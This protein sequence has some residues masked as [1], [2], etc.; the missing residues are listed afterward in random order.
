MKFVSKNLTIFFLTAF[1][2][3]IALFFPNLS[4]ASLGGSPGYF[5]FQ[6]FNN[7]FYDQQSATGV[8]RMDNGF[9]VAKAASGIGNTHGSSVYMDTCISVSGAIDLRQ[10]NTIFLRSDLTLDNGVTF[11]SGGNIYGYDRALILNGDLTIPAGIVIHIGDRIVIDGRGHKLNLGNSAQLFVDA[12][13]TLTLKNLVLD[14]T[15]NQPGHPMVQCAT[16]AS[17]LC[18]DN[19]EIIPGG[20][21]WFNQGQLFIHN[22]VAVTG[23]SALVYR[24]TKPLMI[25]S[26]GRLF[27]D[28]NTTFSV[29]PA[30]FT[31]CPYST[32][33][34]TTTNNFIWMADQ[35]SQLYLNGCT[36][37]TTATGCRFRTGTLLFDNKVNLKSNSGMSIS[38]S[39]PLTDLSNG[40]VTT[41]TTPQQVAWSPDSRY[42]ATEN[43]G[44][45]AG[46]QIF[47]FN[48]N[49]SPQ[50]VSL[51]WTITTDYGN[52]S[53]SPDDRFLAI[54]GNNTLRLSIY[55]LNGASSAPTLL[56]S[57]PILAGGLPVWSPDGRFIALPSTSNVLNVYRFN[58]ISPV[59]VAT[60]TGSGAQ[61]LSWSPDGQFIAEVSVGGVIQIFKFNGINTLTSVGST[62][63]GFGS[64]YGMSWSPDGRFLAIPNNAAN[65][66]AVYFFNGRE[67]PT[68]VGST[69]AAAANAQI[70]SWSPDG[71]FI[72]TSNSAS[73]VLQ[74]FSFN[75]SSAPTQVGG[76]I[77]IAHAA[78]G[79]AWSPD[80][81]FIAAFERAANKLQVFRINYVATNPSPQNL[82]NST[83]FG[84][85]ALGSSYDLSARL[86]S[87]SQGVIDGIVND[88][89]VN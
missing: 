43:N 87:E 82:S 22:D 63:T 10:T 84:N 40:G 20:D 5:A 32:F 83:V 59:Q 58:G 1:V 38:T 64:V 19:S 33:P 52:F 27:F 88:D 17:K 3:L 41:N 61:W 37:C 49:I 15:Q 16:P 39:N 11:S 53:F 68:L 71:R 51:L 70:I 24:T 48:P 9:T 18:L 75:G 54:A 72:V 36:L 78:I 34:T 65:G 35:T 85:S 23:T 4:A 69:V 12:N 7:V 79:A 26:E 44:G 42:V 14:G 86:L 66:L 30:T 77:T 45:T 28:V 47:S 62:S 60:V 73:T 81:N 67:A 21:F 55:L 89:N 6:P 31:D 56:G 25:T 74:I 13:A 29:A 50:A 46:V 57:V 2:F 8:V 76:N 80:G